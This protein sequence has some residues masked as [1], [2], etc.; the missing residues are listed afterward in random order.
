MSEEKSYNE[1]R[2]HRNSLAL[3]VASLQSSL[4]GAIK[5]REL[6]ESTLQNEKMVMEKR[7][8]ELEEQKERVEI[9]LT[10]V[11]RTARL[12][13]TPAETEKGEGDGTL[14]SA[15]IQHD[16]STAANKKKKK[17]KKKG[18]PVA[19]TVSPQSEV[20]ERHTPLASRSVGEFKDNYPGRLLEE[21]LVG[22]N[23]S[24]NCGNVE[25]IASASS[26]LVDGTDLWSNSIAQGLS[27]FQ[28]EGLKVTAE[29]LLKEAEV[30]A[31]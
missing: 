4:D 18:G 16:A 9:E 27:P 24:I 3:S 14:A 11:A 5:A 30:D 8:S 26:Q 20:G 17:K 2:D 12:P 22:M 21:Y 15:A 29:S 23:R 13:A 6:A 10:T 19:T 31:K 7:I 1:I 25:E 28:L